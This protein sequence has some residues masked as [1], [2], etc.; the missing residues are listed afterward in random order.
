M[1]IKNFW[2]MFALAIVSICTISC[3][4]DDDE[5][6]SKENPISAKDLEETLILSGSGEVEFHRTMV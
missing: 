2:M 6:G 4:G 3:G 1:N 5:S